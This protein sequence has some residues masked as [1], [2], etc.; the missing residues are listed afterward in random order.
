MTTKLLKDLG[1]YYN[2]FILVKSCG[3]DYKQHRK[4]SQRPS[5]YNK[6]Y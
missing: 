6:S 5:K 1:K 4:I 3:F 2:K